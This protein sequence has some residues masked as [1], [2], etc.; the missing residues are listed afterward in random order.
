M[1][2][3][4]K[5]IYYNCYLSKDNQFKYYKIEEGQTL[6]NDF[7]EKIIHVSNYIP[8]FLHKYILYYYFQPKI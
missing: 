3:N 4:Q 1:C 5:Y 8:E 6:L 2:N 7:E